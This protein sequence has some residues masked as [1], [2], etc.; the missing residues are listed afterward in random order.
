MNKSID[1][2]ILYE[3]IAREMETAALLS[4]ELKRRGYS[5][6]IAEVGSLRK[7]KKYGVVLLPYLYSTSNLFP[8][9][10]MARNDVRKIINLQYEQVYSQK[11]ENEKKLHPSGLAQKAQ[12]IVWGEATG[13]RLEKFGV[14]KENIHLTGHIGMDLNYPQFDKVFMT[15]KEISRE[16]SL[17]ENKKW[18]LFISSFSYCNMSSAQKKRLSGMI[19]QTDEIIKIQEESKKTILQWFE[20]YLINNKDTYIIYRPHPAEETDNK[21][22]V[23]EKNFSNFKVIKSYSIRQWIKV[24]DSISNWF[25]TSIADIYFANKKCA[26]LRPVKMPRELDNIILDNEKSFIVTEQD[27]KVY[28]EKDITEFPAT[29]A[30]I[31]AYYGKWNDGKCYIRLADLCE[32]VLKDDKYSYDYTRDINISAYKKIKVWLYQVLVNL[33]AYLRVWRLLPGKHR[34]AFRSKYIEQRNYKEIFE[35]YEKVFEQII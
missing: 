26:V 6:D 5:V 34:A 7:G 18:H 12:H 4:A 23:L 11:L 19:G 14:S 3:H 15:R 29:T 30:V 8:V 35:K 20:N 10:H 31:E 21:L 2:I 32:K 17:N 24:C 1:F 9:L 25:S 22:A 33:S 27:F 16:F 13:K 28:M